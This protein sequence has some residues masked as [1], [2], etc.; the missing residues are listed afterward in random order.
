M[1][2][3]DKQ[4]LVPDNQIISGDNGYSLALNISLCEVA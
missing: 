4:F 3:Q 2:V 1:L